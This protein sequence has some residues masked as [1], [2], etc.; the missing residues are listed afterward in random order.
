MKLFSL[1]K[2]AHRYV[3]VH[4]KQSLLTVITTG[5]LFGVFLG[6][7]FLFDGMEKTFVEESDKLTDGIIYTTS[8][9]CAGGKCLEWDA[10]ESL[11]NKKIAPY[12]GEIVGR[13]RNYEYKNGGVSFNVVDES[14][15]EGVI[16]INLG[17]YEKGT[18]FKII[19]LDEAKKLT[20]PS[21]PEEASY[22]LEEKVYSLSEINDL[23]SKVL[24]KHFTETF[25]VPTEEKSIAEVLNNDSTVEE[26]EVIYQEKTLNYV[27]AGVFGSSNSK[28]SISQS[29]K[30]FRILDFL[31]DTMDS[32]VI[33]PNLYV[34]RKSDNI[35]N[36]EALFE[37]SKKDVS[38]PIVQFSDLN[39]AYDYYVTENCSLSQNLDKCSDYTVKELVGNRL[40]A[41]HALRVLYYIFNYDEIALVLIAVA[42][43]VFTFMRL[44]GENARSIAL[45][46]SL[47]AS[48]FDILFIYLFY[49][50]ELCLFAALFAT[51][52]GLT[53]AIALSLKD[54]DNLTTILTSLY[55][56]E[57]IP[58][59]LIAFDSNVTAI[60]LSMLATAPIC[61]ILTLDQLST[62]NITKHLKND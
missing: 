17:E 5:V 38:K 3:A 26:T 7:I 21:K 49:L 11:T 23:K 13:V 55:A 46:R 56:R 58:G 42:I 4:K 29:Y 41:R 30:D 9:S 12:G 25:R 34:S 14:F 45:Y 19:S 39:K 57:V 44:V 37:A 47:G 52:L 61:S 62:K 8:E 48:T 40:N 35:I 16:E 6:V 54:K 33:E 27:V 43:S 31:L 10:I 24:G 60:M 28:L 20:E 36:Y 32:R 50:L 51:L 53:M 1:M 22:A 59:I 2:I 15:V 18:L